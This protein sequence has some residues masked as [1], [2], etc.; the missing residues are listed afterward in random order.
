MPDSIIQWVETQDASAQNVYVNSLRQNPSASIQ[1]LMMLP[2]PQSK[3]PQEIYN[4]FELATS[5]RYEGMPAFAKWVLIQL[6]K[7]RASR[8]GAEYLADKNAILNDL[9]QIYDWYSYAVQNSGVDDQG[10]PRLPIAAYDWNAAKS[11]SDEWHAVMAG[12]GSGLIYE[13]TKP[14]NVVYDF[15][16]GHTIQLVTSKN[17]LEAEGHMLNHCVGGYCEKVEQGHA[18]IYS[19]RDGNNR[20]IATIELNEDGE[21]VEMKSQSNTSIPSE[22]DP[23][24]QEWV[25]TLPNPVWQD[26]E[27]FEY[28]ISNLD[29][30]EVGD[31][32]FD[33]VAGKD[34]NEKDKYGL[35]RKPNLSFI[36][37]GSMIIEVLDKF[38]QSYSLQDDREAESAAHGLLE[39]LIE[40]DKQKAASYKD[41]KN[42][43]YSFAYDSAYSTADAMW[44]EYRGKYEKELWRD[45]REK[46]PEPQEPN[47]YYQNYDSDEEFDD[48]MDRAQREYEELHAE[49][50][51][52]IAN[53]SDKVDKMVEK[54]SED[55]TKAK[56]LKTLS[57]GLR[58]S[59][60]S[61][62]KKMFE[63]RKEQ[64]MS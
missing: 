4:Q 33:L 61:I 45:L 40:H 38:R 59:S 54:W 36:D 8:D 52:E 24:I 32:L 1:D 5:S 49:W 29:K 6:R 57:D 19:L 14:E 42:A 34:K 27:Y 48:A 20:P 17:D 3:I 43:W 55:D 62:R 46:L 15:G 11:A 16:D 53:L 47:I 37:P 64:S 22:Y 10:Q 23:Y 50:E 28:D 39:L 25:E 60:D 56:F 30:S 9:D 51:D 21:V 12:K 31:Y 2:I 18:F 13:P 44:D 7:M 26:L 63:Q 41:P 35:A 58:K